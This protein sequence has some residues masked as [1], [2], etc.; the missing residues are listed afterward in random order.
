MYI[1]KYTKMDS[2]G[3]NIFSNIVYSDITKYNNS[4]NNYNYSILGRVISFL[5]IKTITYLLSVS[6]LIKTIAMGLILT[7]KQ[8]TLRNLKYPYKIASI[9]TITAIVIFILKKLKK[10]VKNLNFTQKSK[11]L[12]ESNIV[13]TCIPLFFYNNSKHSNSQI[14]QI[15]RTSINQNYK[16]NRTDVE[17]FYNNFSQTP[18]YDESNSNYNYCFYKKISPKISILI[19]SQKK[20]IELDVFLK[21]NE[22][23]E[24]QKNNQKKSN[25]AV[26]NADTKNNNK[27]NTN[28]NNNNFTNFELENVNSP[29]YKIFWAY[30][31]SAKSRKHNINENKFKNRKLNN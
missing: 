3:E 21:L 30:I 5:E 17:A 19:K 23:I 29:F 10:A 13:I 12:K 28:N 31:D 20:N 9:V 11:F 4:G 14:H 15:I 24:K 6:K 1:I 16:I 27:T 22:T 2:N 18:Y 25:Y 26:L 7:L 8:V